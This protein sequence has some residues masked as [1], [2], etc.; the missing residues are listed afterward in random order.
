MRS[1][2]CVLEADLTQRFNE[3]V[4]MSKWLQVTIL[5]LL[6]TGSVWLTVYLYQ[7]D[8]DYLRRGVAVPVVSDVKFTQE[9][10]GT[11][12]HMAYQDQQGSTVSFKRFVSADLQTRLRARQPVQVQY[13]PGEWNSERFH[14]ESSGVWQWALASLGFIGALVWTARRPGPSTEQDVALQ[15]P[16]GPIALIVSWLLRGIILM[17]AVGGLLAGVAGFAGGSAG[18]QDAILLLVGLAFAGLFALSLKLRLG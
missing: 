10:S 12:A 16:A 17:M 11:L 13:I 6:S 3:G 9:K 15:A 1:N 7:T 8:L 18:S 14:G 5:L 4:P 2:A